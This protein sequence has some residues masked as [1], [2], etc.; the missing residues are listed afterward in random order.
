[1]ERLLTAATIDDQPL[2]LIG[3]H[4]ITIRLF[5]IYLFPLKIVLAGPKHTKDIERSY[6]RNALCPFCGL[7]EAGTGHRGAGMDPKLAV[8]PRQ[9]SLDRAWRHE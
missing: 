2:S 5:M 7:I 6:C 8:D 4:T 3:V 1:M 9:M